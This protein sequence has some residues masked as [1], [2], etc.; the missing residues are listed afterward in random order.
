[1]SV[2]LKLMPVANDQSQ[3]LTKAVM[4]AAERLAVP[5]NLLSSI[6]GLS[7]ATLSRM[8]SGRYHLETGSKPFEIALLFV[9][10]FRSLDAIAGGD[11]KVAAAWLQN[12]NTALNA[13]PVQKIRSITGLVDVLAYLD[14]RRALV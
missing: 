13:I 11:D 7:E 1:M 9:R 14:A 2:V 10:L 12:Q 8:K 5:A 3:V 4:R 6:I